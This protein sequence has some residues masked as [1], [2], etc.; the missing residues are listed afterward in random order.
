ML[1]GTFGVMCT[2]TFYIK[3]CFA[4]NTFSIFLLK[5]PLFT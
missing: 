5:D 2:F 3:V 1:K 4:D